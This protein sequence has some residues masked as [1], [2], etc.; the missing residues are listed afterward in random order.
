MNKSKI[1]TFTGDT[2]S[3]GLVS[4]TRVSKSDERISLY[5]EVDE[6]NSRIGLVI[7]FMRKEKDYAREINFLEEIQASLFDLGSNLAIESGKRAEW[8]LPTVS[9]DRVKQLEAEID[10]MDAGLDPLKNFILPGGTIVASSIHLCRTSARTV[11]RKMVG[12]A[13]NTGE[14]MPEHSLKFVNRLSDYFFVLARS[15]NKQMGQT[16][17]PWKATN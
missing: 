7:S 3:T 11:E 8:K 10:W 6:L 14:E 15:V 5:G 16:E 1:Y 13:Q 17:T 2:G 12:F 9:A 4:G